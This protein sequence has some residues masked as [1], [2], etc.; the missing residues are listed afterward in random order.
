MRRKWHIQKRIL[1]TL[2]CLTC[3]ILL[4]VALAFNLSMR[5]YIRSRVSSQLTSISQNITE[6]R[7]SGPPEREDGKRDDE[8]P[9]RVTGARGSAILLDGDGKLVSAL[10]GDNAV[11]SALAAY[12]QAR[13]LGG[14]IENDIVTLDIGSY[15]VSA[16]D[17]PV[18]PGQYLLAYVDV[19]SLTALTRQINLVL[20]C[21]ILAAVLLS[22]LLSRYFARSFSE[23]VRTLSAFAEEIGAGNLSP[24]E[25]TFR[26]VEFDALADSMNRMAGDLREAKQKQETFFQNVSHEL[27]TPLTSI[28][29]NAEGVVYG[30]IEPENAAKVILSESDKLGGM[31]EDLLYL[32]RM[33][34][35]VPEGAAE[36]LDLREAI[37]LCVS[38]QRAQAE[39][40]GVRFDF[41]FDEAPVLLPIREPD[42]QRLF[43]NLISNAIRYAKSTVHLT[44]RAT[45]GAVLARV[46]DDGSGISEE[47]LP[48][49]FE[50]FYR[51]KDGKHGIGL[52]IARSVAENWHGTLTAHNVDGAVFEV[53]FP[54]Q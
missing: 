14:G 7:R 39:R 6:E 53:R 17:D 34:R 21:V 31:V 46:A 25:L 20:L 43:G 35:A 8:R 16:T 50:R 18:T 36:P 44:C 15:A 28:R 4:A 19:T 37:S 42:A 49:I 5:G 41:D 9:D 2:I 51:G 48:H 32:S 54:I 30:V 33:G 10:H 38:E 26:D 12:Y 13:G 45:D 23:P 29:G 27:R 24:R 52:A 11:A 47:D 1:V 40:R 3:A 22:V